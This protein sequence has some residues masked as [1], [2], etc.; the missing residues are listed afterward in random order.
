MSL[1]ILTNVGHHHSGTYT[2]TAINQAGSASVE[3]QLRVQGRMDICVGITTWLFDLFWWLF[4]MSL[5]L[6]YRYFIG[7]CLTCQRESYMLNYFYGL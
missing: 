5:F 7:I 1:L 3:T 4:Q 6:S 2:C